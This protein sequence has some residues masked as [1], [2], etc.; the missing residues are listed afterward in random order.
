MTGVIKTEIFRC[1]LRDIPEGEARGFESMEGNNIFSYFIVRRGKSVFAYENSCP[2]TGS[3]L[4]W[5][6][7]QFFDKKRNNLMCATHG[8][9]FEVETGLCIDGPCMGDY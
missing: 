1:S 6:P 5:T 8:A 9:L 2:H 4:D 7:N 3:P